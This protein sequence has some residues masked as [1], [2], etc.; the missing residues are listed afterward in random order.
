MKYRRTP[1]NAI[2]TSEIGVGTYALG[3]VYGE[4]A[5][6]EF[7]SMLRRA[8]ERGVT[9]FDTAPVYGDAEEII[10]EALADVR[11]DVVI[12]T[13]V[14]ARLGNITC[15]FDD[16]VAS[17]E[18]SLKRIGTDYIDLYQIHFDDG[19]T[20]VEEVVRS[21]EHLK[22]AGKILAYGIGHVSLERSHQYLDKGNVSTIM[23]ELNIVSRNYY[24]RMLPL[25]KAQGGG[26]IGFSLTARGIL[27]GGIVSREG[28][29]PQDI[30][31]MDVVFA[32]ERLQSALRIRDRLAKIGTGLGA[33][34][35]QVAIAWALA[36]EGVLTGL[37]GPS[38]A[39]HLDEDL[40]AC[41]LTI[42][43]SVLAELDTFL[44]GEAVR[45]DKALRAEI[46]SVLEK[47]VSD[48]AAVQDLIYAIEA[49]AE[50][51]VAPESGLIV[52]I[53]ALM[54]VMK[55]GEADISVLEQI[56]RELIHY[57]DDL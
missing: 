29:S 23:G 32:G 31:Q 45:L 35:G 33:T 44:A 36:Q 53:G 42:P 49:L 56:R 34:P 17:C 19:R 6:D 3:G 10:G 7:S 21:L 55:T 8:V 52:H 43:D 5:F 22:S 26:Y 41:E 48:G 50:L 39:A 27:T 47:Q 30:R 2:L 20:P 57:I 12:S 37:V 15:S 9:F 46:R 11:Q 14:A 28:L 18:A 16:I 25:I 13:K 38:T 40:D 24:L 51:G 1:D 4:K 54:K